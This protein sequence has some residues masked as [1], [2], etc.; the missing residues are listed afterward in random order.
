[1]KSSSHDSDARVKQIRAGVSPAEHDETHEVD[2]TLAQP[3]C[4]NKGDSMAN[5][6]DPLYWEEPK[7]N[8]KEIAELE[9]NFTTGD[10]GKPTGH[11][12]RQRPPQYHLRFVTRNTCVT[13][14]EGRA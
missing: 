13:C 4:E 10:N 1:V 8:E 3:A 14:A 11:P 9:R 2:A 5:L 7:I 6:M 12:R